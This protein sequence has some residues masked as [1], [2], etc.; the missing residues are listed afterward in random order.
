MSTARVRI[1]TLGLMLVVACAPMMLR[2]PPRIDIVGVQLDRIEGHDAYFVASVALTNEH[3]D[4]I[5]IDALQG[6]LAIE[7]ESVAQ[8]ALASPPVRIPAHGTARAEMFAR[9]GMDAVLRA[10]AAAMRR[11]A[12]VVAPGARPTL[13]YTI[14]GTATLAGGLR[15]P[16]AKGGEIG[17][18]PR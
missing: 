4:E 6:S 14:E 2:N 18:A 16:F 13:R 8:A 9:T 7:G 12:T 11:G 17:G 10:V 15:L 1:A 3:D 5:V